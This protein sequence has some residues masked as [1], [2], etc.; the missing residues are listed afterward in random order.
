MYNEEW[1]TE[2]VEKDVCEEQDREV[3]TARKMGNKKQQ[4]LWRMENDNRYI[5]RRTFWYAS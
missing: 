1:A 2:T 4:E 3:M 5:D